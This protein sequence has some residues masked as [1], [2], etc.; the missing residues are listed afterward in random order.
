M[1]L[2]EKCRAGSTLK[3]RGSGGGAADALLPR[4]SDLFLTHSL[5]EERAWIIALAPTLRPEMPDTAAFRPIFAV[6][7]P[8]C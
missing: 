1:R 6:Q 4:V 5:A 2:Q 8:C 3:R 7:E